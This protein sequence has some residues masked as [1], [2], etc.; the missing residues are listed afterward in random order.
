MMQVSKIEKPFLIFRAFIALSLSVIADVLDFVGGPVLGIPLI[1]DIPNA[2]VTGILYALTGSKKSVALNSIKFIP[3]I[4]DF[5]PI[6][7]L[8]SL[9]WIYTESRKRGIK[10]LEC[11]QG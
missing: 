10:E 1:G 11:L 6:Y 3:F 4:G 9:M 2:I 8:T 7:T 5:I